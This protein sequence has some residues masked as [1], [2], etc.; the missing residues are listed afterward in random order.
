MY[1]T[2]FNRQSKLQIRKIRSSQI[3]Y[4]DT[5]DSLAPVLVSVSASKLGTDD[6]SAIVAMAEFQCLKIVCCY[7]NWSYENSK[8]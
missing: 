6:L 2:E 1:N 5:S 8:L 3:S 4:T 7:Y